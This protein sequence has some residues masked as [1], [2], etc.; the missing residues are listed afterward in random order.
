M[1]P[2]RG[3]PGAPARKRSHCSG[4]KHLWQQGLAEWDRLRLAEIDA[5]IRPTS[6][7][8]TPLP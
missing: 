6:P 7:P 3:V 1:S 2:S 4:K 5:A 8:R